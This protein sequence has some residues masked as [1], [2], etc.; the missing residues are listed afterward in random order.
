LF[1]GVDADFNVFMDAGLTG[2]YN[3]YTT[4]ALNPITVTGLTPVGVP[5]ESFVGADLGS[6]FCSVFHAC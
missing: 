4:T 6:G 2:N 1:L 5:A 3:F